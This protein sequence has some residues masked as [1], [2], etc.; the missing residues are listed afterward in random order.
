MKWTVH[1]P[2]VHISIREI[3]AETEDQAIEM[4]LEDLDT[5]VSHEYS[6]TLDREY[7]EAFQQQEA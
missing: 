7:I 5:E 6:H 4:A 2:E 1:I 3:E